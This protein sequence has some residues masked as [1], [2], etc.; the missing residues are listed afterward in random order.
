MGLPTNY[1]RVQLKMHNKEVLLHK[2]NVTPLDCKDIW[3]RK[4]EFC[5]K[6]FYLIFYSS[7]KEGFF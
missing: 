1:T 5:G 2:E 3:I 4:F 7:L 6:D